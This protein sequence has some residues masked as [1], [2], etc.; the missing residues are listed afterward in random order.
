MK[1]TLRL[2]A[3]YSIGGALVSL[4]SIL[5][6]SLRVISAMLLCTGAILFALRGN[7]Q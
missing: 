4:G 7:A 3:A 1:L 2:S 5:D 6:P